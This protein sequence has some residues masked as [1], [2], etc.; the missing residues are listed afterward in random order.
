MFRSG[1][2]APRLVAGLAALVVLTAVAPARA[3]ARSEAR[4]H[5]KRGMDL[6]GNGKYDDGIAALQR[7][8]ELVPHPNVLYN[9]GRAHGEQGNLEGAI[10]YFRKYLDGNPADKD[11]VL[12]IVQN[13][14]ARLK[15]QQ[16]SLA[17]SREAPKEPAPAPPPHAPREPVPCA[18][19]A[20][21]PPPPPP[22]PIKKEEIPKARTE[23]V[24]AETVTTATKGTQS[25]LDAPSSTSII[26]Q[27]DIRLSGITKIPELLRR[28][29]GLDIM[30]VTGGQT[31]VSVRGFNQRLSNKTL[32]LVDGRSV[33]VDLLGATFWQLLSIGVEDIDRIEVVRGPGSAL[34]GAD[35][36]NGVI[37][38]LTKRPGAGK[39]GV[40]AGY[41]TQG[42]TH[43]SFWASGN[44]REF[45]WRASAGYDYLPRWSR[46]VPNGRGDIALGI[47]DQVQASRT[48]R[49]DVRGLRHLG[50]AATIGLGGGL[51]QGTHEVLGIGPLNDVILDGITST[52][53]TATLDS[54]YFE[55]RVFYTRLRADNRLNVQTLGQSLLPG[56]A[57]AN[58]LD[59][60]AQLKVRLPIGDASSNE[61]RA[62]GFYR[63]KDVAWTFL[64]RRRFEHH[65]GFFLHDELR[66]GERVSVVADYRLDRVPY[67]EAFVQSPRGAVIMRPTKQSSVRAS[68][69]TAFRKPTF[70]ESYLDLPI[71]LPLAGGAVFSEGVRSDARGFKVQPERI[72]SAEVGYRNQESEYFVFDGALFFNRAQS[73]IQLAPIRSIT[74]GDVARGLGR[75][76]SET[77]LFPLF[78]GGFDNG[79]QVFNVYGAEAGVRTFPI[80]GLDF[81]ANYTLHL[82]RQDNAACTPEQ[83]RLVVDDQRTSVHKVNAG[84]QLRTTP[85]FDASVDF[86]VVTDQVWAEQVTDIAS[87]RVLLDRFQLSAYTL[88]NGRVA[89]RFLDNQ[90]DASLVVWNALD[91]QHR[92]HPFGQLVRRRVMGFLT[93]RF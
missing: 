83:I 85:G 80:E 31:E 22:P 92:E 32:V 9:I 17:A 89:Y 15:R 91:V 90:A 13:L 65:F 19:C 33:Y 48:T 59:G 55:T 34:Y 28:L 73:L 44:A 69:A 56:R 86:H 51:V 54:K 63:Y 27:Q 40:S 87:Q 24:F 37:N 81:H 30:E 18:P 57:E 21:S 12:A 4:T 64:D 2:R 84:V 68:A 50:T 25:P 45:G 52:D 46:E 1:P 14:E 53:L 26:T 10:E 49:I 42:Q 71:Q 41:G 82:V 5:F 29:A 76:D 47:S 16:A 39:S 8:Y 58:V 66:L 88:L 70:L 6:I 74:V 11:D 79:C 60:E 67:L 43:G 23:D 61:L 38:I 35:A 3:D 93:Y 7:A 75:Q 20:T 72:Y 77:G 62:G 78:F 36:F